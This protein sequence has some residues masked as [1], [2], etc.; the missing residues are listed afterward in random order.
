M[1][2]TLAAALKQFGDAA[3]ALADEFL[4]AAD[5]LPPLPPPSLA[6]EST[7]FV[8]DYDEEAPRAAQTAPE[9]QEQGS[10]AICPKHRKPFKEGRYGPFC[11]STTDDPAW[12]KERDGKMWCRI[13]P[14]NAAEWLRVTAAA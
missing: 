11:T 10:L 3:Y 8:A 5:D 2:N 7:E 12:G 13:T 9:P 4:K 1:T 14:K 6:D